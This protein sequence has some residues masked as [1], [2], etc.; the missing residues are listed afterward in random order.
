M[1]NL[2]VRTL[3]AVIA[4]PVTFFL[5]WFNDATRLLLMCFMSGAG[6]WEWSRMASKMVEGPSMR[7]VAPV[8][9]IALVIA[10]ILES[11]N[12]FGL[13]A[14]EHLVGVVFVCVFALYI[15]I[16]FAKVPVER[17]FPWL[18][19]QLGAPLY[20]GLWGGL[21]I[22]LLGSG[23]CNLEHSYKFI[24]VMT[25]M[26]ICDTMA[27]FGGRL[28]GKHLFAPEISPKK[29]WE[30]AVCG[31]LFA[32]GWVVFFAPSVFGL[33][34]VQAIVLGFVLAVAGQVGDLFESTLKRWSGT[35]DASQIFPGHGGV[36]DRMDSFF[37]AAPAVV[38]LLA[39]F[40]NFG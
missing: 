36:L 26:W 20:I 15:A 38:L 19:L 1:S 23:S 11:G 33:S 18:S 2:A 16:A 37:L 13:S 21:D 39:F 22:Y 31:T 34:Y 17:L 5:L 30:G 10:W 24:L 12:F 8:A 40:K 28:L 27:Y 14:V 3:F 32:V 4:I 29:T 7:F 9:S 25:A 35:K 6:A